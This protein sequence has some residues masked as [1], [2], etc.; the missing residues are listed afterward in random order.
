MKLPGRRKPYTEIGIGRVPCAR[1]GAPSVHQW[2]CCAIDN[3]WLPLC[4][5][6]DIGLNRAALEFVGE[7]A[8]DALMARYEARAA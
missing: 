5:E 6:C 3:R 1:C 4:L 7:P 2:Q 8:I